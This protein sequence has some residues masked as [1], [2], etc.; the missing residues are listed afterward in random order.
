MSSC[1]TTGSVSCG[2]GDSDDGMTKYNNNRIIGDCGNLSQVTPEAVQDGQEL[3][4]RL[5]QVLDHMDQLE[6]TA[7]NILNNISPNKNTAAGGGTKKK[8]LSKEGVEAAQKLLVSAKDLKDYLPCVAPSSGSKSSSSSPSNSDGDNDTLLTS[9]DND[10]DEEGGNTTPTSTTSSNNHQQISGGN[11]GSNESIIETV[12][13]G[14]STIVSI[15]DPPP[16]TSIFGMDVMRGCMLSRYKNV[17]QCG[18]PFP[19][20]G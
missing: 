1:T 7:S 20:D 19:R 5:R 10:S 8:A 2:G 13:S 15:F 16:H 6:Y 3:Y 14:I 12:K 4:K 9:V 11:Q 18:Y 17:R